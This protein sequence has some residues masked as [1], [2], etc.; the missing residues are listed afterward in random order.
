MYTEDEWKMSHEIGYKVSASGHVG[1][2]RPRWTNCDQIEDV[3]KK[4]QA[5]STLIRR[6]NYYK[7][8]T[9]SIS[10]AGKSP[11]RM[12]LSVSQVTYEIKV[13][14]TLTFQQQITYEKTFQVHHVLDI[15]T[16]SL[17]R[18][19]RRNQQCY[20]TILSTMT[21]NSRQRIIKFNM[22]PRCKHIS[23]TRNL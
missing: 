21:G 17:L 22:I 19:C 16:K 15:I 18:N 11:L 13:L 10:F 23:L 4:G 8:Q 14:L 20:L 5:M 6:V 12:S 9:S 3:L 2:G 1:K 7:D